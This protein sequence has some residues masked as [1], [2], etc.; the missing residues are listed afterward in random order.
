MVSDEINETYNIGSGQEYKNMEIL[1]VI[2]DVL[3]KTPKFKFVSDR[4]GHDR[5]YSLNCEKYKNRFG[6][7][8]KINFKNWIKE[9]INESISIR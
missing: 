2:S 9:Q 8:S 4:L 6:D 5:R 1:D 7:I 3:G